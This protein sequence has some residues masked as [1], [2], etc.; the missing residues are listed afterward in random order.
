MLTDVLGRQLAAINSFPT[1]HE[2]AEFV[3][4]LAQR[5]KRTLHDHQEMGRC[6]AIGVVVP[7]MVDD[8][9]TRVLRAPTLGWQDV[10]L[11]ELLVA[12]TRI[13]VQ[14]ENSGKACVLAQMWAG[15]METGDDLV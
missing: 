4:Q 12:A 9:M 2:P 6:Q 11:R 1:P 14:M 13:P 5:I 8:Q 7:G 10:P 3:R 15:N